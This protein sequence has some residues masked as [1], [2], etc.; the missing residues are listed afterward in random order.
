[1]KEMVLYYAPSPSK[2]VNL[3]KSVFV[4]MGIRIKNISPEQAGQQVGFLAGMEGF[5]EQEITEPIPVME[6]EMLVMKYFTSRRVDELLLN[7]RKAGVPKIAL[8]AVVTESNSGWT[9][10]HLYEELKEEHQK[11]QE[12]SGT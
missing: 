12:L 5:L 6:E 1:M 8:K 2:H 7:L 10:Y 3:L 9:L 11:M 4:R